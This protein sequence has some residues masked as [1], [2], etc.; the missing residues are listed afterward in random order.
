[1]NIDLRE[2]LPGI[3]S[4]PFSLTYVLVQLAVVRRRLLAS[5]VEGSVPRVRSDTT[6]FLPALV[7]GIESVVHAQHAMFGPSRFCFGVPL[8]AFA[9]QAMLSG[10][11]GVFLIAG[12]FL[13]E[14]WA[15]RSGRAVRE[16]RNALPLPVVAAL[17]S[18]Q[19]NWSLHLV[20]YIPFR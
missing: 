18:V 5:V 9:S 10:A 8:W 4:Y 1:M 14:G 3:V 20:A 7:W 2:V 19:L 13:S 15:R 11:V 17:V 6:Y 16:A 12:G